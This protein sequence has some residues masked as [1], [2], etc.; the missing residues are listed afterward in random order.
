MN[1]NFKYS[2]K[3]NI[4]KNNASFGPGV[5]KLLKLVNEKGNLT[6]AYEE[7]GL[8]SSKGWRII[9]NAEKDLGFPLIITKIGGTHGGGSKLS[10]EGK[11]FLDNYE[12][13]VQESEKQLNSI[14][15]KYFGS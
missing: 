12:N 11:I 6:K 10:N 15:K 13:F 4:Y 2:I 8:S 9:K 14:F 5:A 1:N 7:M 3:I